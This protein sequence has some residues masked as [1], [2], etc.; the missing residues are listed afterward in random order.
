[1]L[2]GLGYRAS[3]SSEKPASGAVLSGA[4]SGWT[5]TTSNLSA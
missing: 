3:T 4:M 2:A 1:M 5:N